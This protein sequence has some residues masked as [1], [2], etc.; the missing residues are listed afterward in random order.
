MAPPMSGGD[1]NL[2]LALAW[3][4]RKG[5]LLGFNVFAFLLILAPFGV[6]ASFVRNSLLWLTLN[7]GA[8]VALA[9]GAVYVLAIVLALSAVAPDHFRGQFGVLRRG[10]IGFAAGATALLAYVF[11][12]VSFAMANLGWVT[13]VNTK[14]PEDLVV[15]LSESYMWHV[16]D[17]IPAIEINRSLGQDMP[18]IVL[19]S[20]SVNGSPDD[21]GLLLLAFRLLVALL[22]FRTIF[23]L[24]ER[25]TPVEREATQRVEM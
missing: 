6:A 16:Y 12:G 21:K 20:V 19:E 3:L 8:G 4:K 5:V 15:D 2:A 17:L 24:F 23:R 14:G 22:L 11:A 7:A 10:L 18:R 1:S 13:Y 9:V 25:P